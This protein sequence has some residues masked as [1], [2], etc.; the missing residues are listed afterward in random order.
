MAEGCSEKGDEHTRGGQAASRRSHGAASPQSHG[1]SRGRAREDRQVQAGEN[2]PA[3]QPRA[4]RCTPSVCCTHART[5]A[6]PWALPSCCCIPA[7]AHH[8]QSLGGRAPPRTLWR[9]EPAAANTGA[10]GTAVWGTKVREHLR[11]QRGHCFARVPLG[12]A[13]ND[14]SHA[15]G[16]GR[17]HGDVG[18]V[19]R[20]TDGGG[21][22]LAH[23]IRC[24][25]LP[26]CPRRRRLSP[27]RSTPSVHSCMRTRHGHVEGVPCAIE[28]LPQT[29]GPTA[30]IHQPCI[31]PFPKPA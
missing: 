25:A 7:R 14:G 10:S 17:M 16:C 19:S 9:R 26:S 21:S 18:R 22:S 6:H 1:S 3:E 12:A 15:W 5:S 2:T 8:A 11:V 4:R 28:H 13:W 23:S 24:A 30:L 29:S 20:A 27:L 31:W